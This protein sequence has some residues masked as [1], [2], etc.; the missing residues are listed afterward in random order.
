M[1]TAREEP[2]GSFQKPG[3]GRGLGLRNSQE[4][5]VAGSWMGVE[6]VSGSRRVPEMRS[7]PQ[8]DTAQTGVASVF[9]PSAL[10]DLRAAQRRDVMP[11]VF[12]RESL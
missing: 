11:T 7:R 9:I 10:A 3:A 5:R 1:W 4:V 2:S 12:Y 6:A 8:G